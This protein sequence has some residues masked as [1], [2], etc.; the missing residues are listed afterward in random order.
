MRVAP[1]SEGGEGFIYAPLLSESEVAVLKP[2][3]PHW[4]VM[5]NKPCQ[6]WNHGNRDYEPF[7]RSGRRQGL[8][9]GPVDLPRLR[10]GLPKW[11]AR[12]QD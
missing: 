10:G 9:R 6:V 3:D 7:I 1:L 12:R 2:F 11:H 5:K 4:S 8:G